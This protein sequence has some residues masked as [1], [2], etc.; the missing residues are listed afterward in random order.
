MFLICALCVFFCYM[1][2][3]CFCYM[4]LVCIMNS[5]EVE[6]DVVQKERT[7]VKSS[8]QAMDEDAG[9]R[10]RM[11]APDGPQPTAQMRTSRS[12]LGCEPAIRLSA[13]PHIESTRPEV[14]QVLG[15]EPS[16]TNTSS[17]LINTT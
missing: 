6:V 3:C 10:R 2:P 7:T 8:V 13:N 12:A 1:T 9:A 17:R 11:D 14:A 5:V 15:C 4:A 16:K